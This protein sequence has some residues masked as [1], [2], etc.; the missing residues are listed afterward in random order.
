MNAGRQVSAAPISSTCTGR[1]CSS[2][3]IH[4]SS[5]CADECRRPPG[6]AAPSAGPE[7]NQRGSLL[8]I[9]WNGSEPVE[10]RGGASARS[11][12]TAI[13][14]VMRG[15]CQGNGYRVGFGEV[16][17]TICRRKRACR[18]GGDW[19]RAAGFSAVDGGCHLVSVV[20]FGSLAE[21][22]ATDPQG[23][24]IECTRLSDGR[25]LATH[26][27]GRHSGAG[28]IGRG[29]SLRRSSGR[30]CGAC[31]PRSPRRTC[32]HRCR[33]APPVRAG[34]RVPVA[35]FA[36][37]PQLQCHRSLP[38]VVAPMLAES[39]WSCNIGREPE[40]EW[41]GL[42]SNVDSPRPG[43]DPLRPARAASA[44]VSISFNRSSTIDERTCATL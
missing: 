34:G 18:V 39:R 40:C 13:A 9:S 41:L 19:R 4:A 33:C 1:R 20:R 32:I 16:E 24:R 3:C 14:L 17:G 29:Q 43:D 42:S 25:C 30:H 10:L 21:C 44:A 8:E 37:R 6:L 7:K 22:A 28:R 27:P 12:K 36:V 26:T 5:G 11:W 2:W 35:I 23:C 31:P 15:W 38:I